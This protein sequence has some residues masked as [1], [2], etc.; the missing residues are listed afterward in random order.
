MT[1][2]H[3]IVLPG[4]ISS[5]ATGISEFS[6]NR[7]TT[8]SGHEI[9]SENEQLIRRKYLINEC[10][11]SIEE[12]EQFNIFFMARRGSRFGFLLKDHFDSQA[13]RQLI[14]KG[15]GQT[16]NYH[17]Q[18]TYKDTI[19]PYVRIIKYPYDRSVKLYINNKI[20]SDFQI[21]QETRQ[22]ILKQP[23][24]SNADLLA[25]FSF[26][27]PVRFSCDSYK[28]RFHDDGSIILSD[29]EIQEVIT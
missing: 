3:N 26:F 9:C 12:F 7:V 16:N 22:I 2:I 23:L 20:Y 11:L 18:K 25:T 13:V 27:I 10:R 24:P 1:I 15:D 14:A 4:N 5:C 21:E 6:N 29:I 17:L 8:K 19:S 28:Y